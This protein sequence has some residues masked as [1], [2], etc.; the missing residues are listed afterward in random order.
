MK[1]KIRFYH[2]SPS[3][4]YNEMFHTHVAETNTHSMFNNFFAKIVPFV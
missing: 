2:I 3:Y 4:S 1:T